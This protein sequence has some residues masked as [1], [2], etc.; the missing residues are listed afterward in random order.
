MLVPYWVGVMNPHW[1]PSAAGITLGWTG[2]HRR[3]HLYRAIFE[4][5]AFE[6]R[7]AGDGVMAAIGK[8]FRAYRTVGGGSRSQVWCQMIADVTGVVVERS[9]SVEAT[10]LG[11]GIL[12][13]AAAGW[14]GSTRQ[15][16]EAMTG[17]RDR[18]LPDEARREVYDRLYR[19]VYQNVFP[20]MRPLV[21]RLSELCNQGDSGNQ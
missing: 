20:A 4:G 21:D 8:P 6:Q 11:A 15:A 17:I 18:F 2:D 7:L 5:V 12:A 9:A 3:E 16:A 19:E 13:A 1:D 10:C 14:Y